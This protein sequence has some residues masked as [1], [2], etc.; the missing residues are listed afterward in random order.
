MYIYDP[1]SPISS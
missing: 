1:T